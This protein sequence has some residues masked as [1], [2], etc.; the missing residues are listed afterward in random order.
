MKE[1]DQFSPAFLHVALHYHRPTG[2]ETDTTDAVSQINCV[3]FQLDLSQVFV[4]LTQ[5]EHTPDFPN[6]FFVDKKLI[7]II[8][9]LF[10]EPGF[11]T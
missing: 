6:A 9:V 1:T 10:K 11:R 2:L 8:K 4:T 5:T 3:S 7:L